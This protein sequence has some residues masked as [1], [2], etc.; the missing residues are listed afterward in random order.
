[1]RALRR[2]AAAAL[3]SAA[4]LAL[5]GCGGGGAADAAAQQGYVAG[6]GATTVVAPADRR[7]APD[8]RGTTLDGEEFDLAA[9]RGSVVVLNV[10]ASWCPP[11]RAEA[12]MLQVLADGLRPEGVAFVGV[13]TRDGDGTAARAFVEN[14]GL[15]Y[16]NVVDPDGVLLLAFRDTLPPQAVPSTLVIDRQGRIAARVIGPTTEPRLRA[17]ITTVLD[18]D[19]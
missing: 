8:L 15:S 3:L 7:S 6:D 11:C 5:A 14:V 12:P 9:L 2:G 13:D 16:P 10:W 1:M 17:L 19:S 4:V 18:E